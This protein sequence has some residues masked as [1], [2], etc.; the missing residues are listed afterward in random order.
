MWEVPQEIKAVNILKYKYEY[1]NMPTSLSEAT[2]NLQ[3][4]I[5]SVLFIRKR[6][7]IYNSKMSFYLLDHTIS[8]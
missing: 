7:H 4:Y 2:Q 3:K 8:G 6:L 1:I 5:H